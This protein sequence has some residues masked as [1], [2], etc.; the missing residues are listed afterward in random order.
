MREILFRGKR[1]DNGLD[2][3]EG[4]ILQTEDG[5]I[6]VQLDDKR[7]LTA[8]DVVPETIGQFT[9]LTDRNGKKVFEG[10]ICKYGY[11][12]EYVGELFYDVFEFSITEIDIENVLSLLVFDRKKEE[13]FFQG[14]VVGNVHDNPKLLKQLQEEK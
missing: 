6:I 2:W 3:V 7:K 13:W 14:V 4:G 8:Y 11:D 9:G 10:D 1:A 5:F 12:D